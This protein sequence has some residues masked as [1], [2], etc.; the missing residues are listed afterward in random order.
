MKTDYDRV[1]SFLGNSDYA[2]IV[3]IAANPV[4]LE[5]IL[6]RSY[7]EPEDLEP[8]TP[9]AWEAA[10]A[11]GERDDRAEEMIYR[12]LRESPQTWEAFKQTVNK[13]SP[14]DGTE[15][16]LGRFTLKGNLWDWECPDYIGEQLRQS[17]S[18][19]S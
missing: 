6:S 15:A 4:E 16:F 2:A 10:T 14:Q 17:A 3:R 18:V 9:E 19:P 11:E 13:L 7:S 8:D 5:A 1:M 12:L